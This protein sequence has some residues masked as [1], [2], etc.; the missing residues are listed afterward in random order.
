MNHS[1]NASSVHHCSFRS[2]LMRTEGGKRKTC[3]KNVEKLENVFRISIP[4][5]GGSCFI[6]GLF[7]GSGWKRSCREEGGEPGAS[8]A[9]PPR[10]GRRCW[11]RWRWT[12]WRTWRTAAGTAGRGRCGAARRRGPPSAAGAAP[13]PAA[14]GGPRGTGW[15]LAVVKRCP[16]NLENG[17]WLLGRWL[18]SREPILRQ[19]SERHGVKKFR[20]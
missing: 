6:H 5:P 1:G 10:P 17:R 20:P 2:K 3:T 12:R 18:R 7:L 15:A 4:L 19:H 11:T 9:A 13:P 14:A 16:R 8:P